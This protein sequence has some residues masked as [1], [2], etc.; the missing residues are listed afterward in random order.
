MFISVSRGNASNRNIYIYNKI[1]ILKIKVSVIK[2][3]II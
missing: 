1:I 3:E 2:I